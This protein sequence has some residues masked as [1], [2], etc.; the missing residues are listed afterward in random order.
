MK[1]SAILYKMAHKAV[2]LSHHM[3]EIESLERT[4]CR[5]F[6][7]SLMLLITLLLCFPIFPVHLKLDRH[8]LPF[9]LSGHSF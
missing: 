9:L 5:G 6:I 3:V 8:T 1:L 2:H 7:A 4:T